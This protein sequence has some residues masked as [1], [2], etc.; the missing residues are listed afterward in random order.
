MVGPSPWT[1][2]HGVH[3]ATRYPPRGGGRIR[4][5]ERLHPVMPASQV[6]AR[7]LADDPAYRIARVGRATPLVTSEGEHGAWVAVDGMRDGAWVRRAIGMIFADDF[8]VAFDVLA[9]NP[10][11]WDELDLAARELVVSYE[12]GLGVRRRRYIY[13]P[14]PGWTSLAR[15]LVGYFYPPG[16][17]RDP[18]LLVAYPATPASE[19]ASPRLREE[20]ADG[21]TSTQ[22][23]T[24]RA[25]F[26]LDGME[27]RHFAITGTTERSQ[28]AVARHAIA[29]YGAPYLY[30]VRIDRPQ[31]DDGSVPE[32]LANV[33]KSIV[34]VPPSEP[35]VIPRGSV[36][37]DHW[38][39]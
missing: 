24:D 19:L 22:G 8:V 7:V 16:F 23:V 35:R 10:E 25:F 18:T 15:G 14:P 36:A 29:L 17:P 4:V 34:P 1:E 6:V 27:A 13:T 20:L 5:Y 32:A 33:V 28:Q 11:R 31:P 30:V 21:I 39:D 12:L 3:L 38:I 2:H 9:V 26:V 37:L